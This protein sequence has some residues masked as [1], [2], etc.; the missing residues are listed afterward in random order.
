MKKI[1]VIEDD[2]LLNQALVIT[3]KK[4]GYQVTTGKSCR[5]GIALLQDNPDLMLVDRK[6]VV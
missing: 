3:L 4:E 2:E 5:D 1:A 6:S